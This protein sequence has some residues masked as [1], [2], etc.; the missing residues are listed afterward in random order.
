MPWREATAAFRCAATYRD[1]GAS[2]ILFHGVNFTHSKSALCATSANTVKPQ[3]LVKTRP[4]VRTRTNLHDP[5]AMLA[6]DGA[7]ALQ[8]RN[9]LFCAAAA[10]DT[11]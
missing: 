9:Q 11:C 4:F 2:S 6:A 10:N 3:G 8:N 1:S 5:S 7:A